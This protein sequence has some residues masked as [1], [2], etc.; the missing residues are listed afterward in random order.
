MSGR[1]ERLR[2]YREL[3]QRYSLDRRAFERLVAEVVDSLPARFREKLSN[4]AV[5]V[6]ESPSP[7]DRSSVGLPPCDDLM[8]LY[9]GTPYGDRGTG[10]HLVL[11]DRITIYRRPILARCDS[12]AE[13]RDEIRST[14]LHEIG[15]YFGLSDDELE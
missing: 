3:K 5:V 7:L 4:V 14:V 8:G 9:Q 2:P 12:E 13:A 10:Y 6:A 15:H 1:Q 11:P